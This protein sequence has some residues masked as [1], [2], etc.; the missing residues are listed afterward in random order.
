MAVAALALS[1]ALAACGGGSS[2]VSSKSSKN[3]A[4]SSTTAPAA[5]PV[6][7]VANS[8]LGMILVGSNGHTLYALDKDTPT[9]ATCTGGCAGLWP[10]LTATGTPTGGPGV[11]ATKLTILTGPNGMQVV[12]AGHPLYFF[13]QDSA[14]GDVKGQGFAG[15]IWH[16]V[17]PTGMAITTATTAAGASSGASSSSSPGGSTGGSTGGSSGGGSGMHSSGGYGY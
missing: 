11:D 12:F 7:S 6:V 9:M 4:A 2:N 13:S 15:N 10:P 8:S 3:S 1:G 17:S 14:A 5:P 16:V